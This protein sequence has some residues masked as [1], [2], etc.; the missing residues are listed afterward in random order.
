MF[1]PAFDGTDETPEP[2]AAD[3]PSEPLEDGVFESRH[4]PCEQKERERALGIVSE[5]GQ[6]SSVAGGTP[7]PRD[8][9]KGPA[10]VKIIEN[11]ALSVQSHE[12]YSP[13]TFPL[14]GDDLEHVNEELP[15]PP[16]VFPLLTELH[17]GAVDGHAS[18][19]P[20][21]PTESPDDE[22]KETKPIKL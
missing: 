2:A 20:P 13:R 11:R 17:D 14:K 21:T 22:S 18:P 8:H 5:T 1:A 15:R 4:A 9:S 16:E 12:T 7:R 3:G 19:A 10:A 6:R